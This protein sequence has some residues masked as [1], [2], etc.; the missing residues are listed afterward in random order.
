[1]FVAGTAGGMDG[2]TAIGAG[3][4][5]GVEAAARADDDWGAGMTPTGSPLDGI[6][7]G[8]AGVGGRGGVFGSLV[9]VGSGP[10]GFRGLF[11]TT[12]GGGKAT[13]RPRSRAVWMSASSLV[14]RSPRSQM[15]YAPCSFCAL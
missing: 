5:G 8:V 7:F 10:D 13:F 1:M 3:G 6:S 12:T 14:G 4:G 15:L 11:L 9:S 2:V